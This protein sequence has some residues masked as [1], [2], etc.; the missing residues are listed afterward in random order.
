VIGFIW[1]IRFSGLLKFITAINYNSFMDLPRCGWVDIKMDLGEIQW[2]SM[3]WIDLA[4][5]KD[6]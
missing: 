1:V 5:D 6:Q 2:G 4:Q 3:D